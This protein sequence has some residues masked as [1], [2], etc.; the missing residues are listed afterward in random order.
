[1]QSVTKTLS[2]MLSSG[3]WGPRN[4]CNSHTLVIYSLLISVSLTLASCLHDRDQGGE[5]FLA[6]EILWGCSQQFEK[7][8]EVIF[9]KNKVLKILE[10]TGK[11]SFPWT[12]TFLSICVIYLGNL[13]RKTSQ[14]LNYFPS[15]KNN[16]FNIYSC[17]AESPDGINWRSS[18]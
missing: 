4:P 13:L 2:W 14:K 18:I 17:W 6:W 1:M 16:L 8:N 12:G 15:L 7:I 11:E 10:R 5:T 3:R 9:Y